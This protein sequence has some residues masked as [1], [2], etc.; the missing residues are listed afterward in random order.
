MRNLLILIGFV[1]SSPA[2]AISVGDH[3]E[4]F[5]LLDQN[6]E[7]HQLYYYSDA[8]ALVFM[9]QG[10]G[11]PIVRNALPRFKELR[12]QYSAQGVQFMM[13]NSNLQDNR[14]SIA[15]EASEF[16][17]GMPVLLD[18][19]Q[20]IGESLGLIRTG[21]V[22]VVDPKGWKVVYQGAVD[23]RL[24][25]EKQ[26]AA[27]SEHYLKDAIDEVLAGQP[28]KV[29]STDALGCLI[30]FPE[31][32]KDAQH[33]QISYADTIAPMLIDNCVSCHR[34]GGIGPW[35]MTDY[36]MVR[37]FSLMMR[38]VL[39]TQRMP[40]W[41]ADPAYGHFS[42]DRSLTAQEYTTLVR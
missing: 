31:R 1:F 2:F 15:A 13:I 7:S 11:C 8:K 29:A 4:N 26:K 40:P 12:D 33:A 22:F 35:A 20:V 36:N 24:T 3:V 30:N 9:V 39:R 25:Y 21:E 41:H 17:F 37:G 10:N 14:A 19:T 34:P 38:E 18:E 32:G 6:G 16:D 5:R 27:A 23:D 28:V 42:N